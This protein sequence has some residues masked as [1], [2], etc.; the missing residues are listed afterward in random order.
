MK[1]TVAFL[2]I[3]VTVGFAACSTNPAATKTVTFTPCCMTGQ[4]DKVVLLEDS[5]A[6]G[7]TVVRLVH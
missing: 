5:Y 7:G 3:I 6:S 2:A 4:P 1:R